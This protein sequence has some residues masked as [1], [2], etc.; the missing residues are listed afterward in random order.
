[1][2]K[3]LAAVVVITLISCNSETTQTKKEKSA[4]TALEKKISKRDLTINASNAYSDLFLDSTAMISFF[5]QEKP[6][7]SLV[8]RITSFYNTR[9]YQY[10]WFNSAGL[11]E[12][13][14]GFWNLHE[15]AATYSNDSFL[16]NKE[17]SKT[18]NTLLNA[19]S[20]KL[21][22]AQKNMLQAELTLTSHFILYTLNNVE[23]G[24][25]KRKEME[26]FVPRFK[27]DPMQLADSLLTKKHKDGKYYADVNE[28]YKQL[29]TQ[30]QHYYDV[31]KAGG[32]PMID[33]SAKSLKT[34][35]GGAD[36]ILLKKRLFLSGDMSQDTLPVYDAAL[37]AGINNFQ[38][39]HGY[40]AT[41]Q[42][43]DAQ[44]KDMNVPVVERV[45]QL[46]VNMGRMQWIIHQP[47]GQLLMVN[48]PEFKLHVMEGKNKAFEMPVVV[49][50]QGNNTVMF[51]GNLNQVVF[52]PYW[53]VTPDIV[54]EEIYPA[55]QRDPNYL[56]SHNME[57]TGTDG[58]LPVVRQLPGPDNS[59]G[60]VKFLF[61]NS[62][63]IYFHDTPAKSLF[64]KDKRAFSH[65][66]IRL[67]EPA[68]LARYLLKDQSAWSDDK[69][70]AAMN[71]GEEKY[72][73]LQKAIPVLITY[74]TAWV[75]ANGLLHFAED[76]YGHDKDVAEKMFL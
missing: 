20:V 25:I 67:A 60:Q 54:K 29:K 45:K 66:C 15:Y 56:A 34:G 26:R 1:M 64:Q 36:I 28:P 49:G 19:S 63:N 40:A 4:K 13:G 17:L 57:Q 75:D 16:V 22:A 8:R 7:D 47:E 41:G 59:L 32:W 31:A 37:T 73:K 42:L 44:L 76:I 5:I 6:G 14:R 69:I 51:T 9:N 74:Y 23:E 46:L 11:T 48:I 18:I 33:A 61:P 12:Q 35:A 24:F 72:V 52:S 71:S 21:S 43:T 58:G 65:G 70:D 62:F 2:K 55:M 68:K 10:A 50:K 3:I 30:L 38:L 39:R 53:N 27:E